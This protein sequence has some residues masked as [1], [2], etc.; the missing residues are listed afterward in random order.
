MRAFGEWKFWEERRESWRDIPAARGLRKY[1]H[2][3]LKTFAAW[4]HQRNRAFPVADNDLHVR[5]ANLIRMPSSE[6]TNTIKERFK[7]E[8]RRRNLGKGMTIPRQTLFE[9]AVAA[10]IPGTTT[11]EKFR[12]KNPAYHM[13]REYASRWRYVRKPPRR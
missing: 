12:D 8:C 1:Y 6:Q 3:M 10:G 7:I 11:I 5:T 4:Y 13:A 2:E 9:I